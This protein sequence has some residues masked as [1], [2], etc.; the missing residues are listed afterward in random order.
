MDAGPC[1][2]GH[3]PL[4][5][6]GEEQD[7]NLCAAGIVSGQIEHIETA[8][9]RKRDVQDHE[10][11]AVVSQRIYDERAVRDH[12]GADRETVSKT[13]GDDAGGRRLILG[14][15][16]VGHAVRQAEAVPYLWPFPRASLPNRQVGPRSLGIDRALSGPVREAPLLTGHC[17]DCG[18]ALARALVRE[19]RHYEEMRVLEVTC[20]LC[21]RRFVAIDAGDQRASPLQVEDV[22]SASARLAAA[23]SLAD[24]FGAPDFDVSDAGERK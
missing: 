22:T 4:G 17:A 15:Q 6:G 9:T 13:F 11:W 20:G 10:L 16:Y 24:L 3:C 1:Q 21:E 7:G 5:C 14:D 18:A 12:L 19:V 8:K 2:D 23:R